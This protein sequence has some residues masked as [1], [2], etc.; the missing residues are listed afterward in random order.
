MIIYQETQK[1]PQWVRYLPIGSG[2]MVIVIIVALSLNGDIPKNELL[3]AISILFVVELL[4]FLILSFERMKII[5]SEDSIK[6]QF[7]IFRMFNKTIK[8]SNIEHIQLS[9]SKMMNFG[10]NWTPYNRREYK[11]EGTKGLLF[12]HKN[13]KQYFITCRHPELLLKKIIV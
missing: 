8:L 3:L 5:I 4:T 12:F 1:Y 6:I 9:K 11:M 2:I 10:Y 7:Q 13:G